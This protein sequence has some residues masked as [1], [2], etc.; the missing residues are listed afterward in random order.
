MNN[1]SIL[2]ALSNKKVFIRTGSID[3][4]AGIDT[5]A[6]IAASTNQEEFFNGALFVYCSRSRTQIRIIFW[7]GCGVWLLARKLNRSR[8]IWPTKNS[9]NEDVLSCYKDLQSL[10]KD[11]ISW[12]VISSENVAK[13]LSKA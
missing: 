7:E 1:N 2:S 12:D 6:A 11:P 4:R 8:F 10:L 13:K 3:F 5:L 9:N